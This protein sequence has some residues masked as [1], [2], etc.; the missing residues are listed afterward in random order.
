MSSAP[1]LLS[2][3]VPAHCPPQFSYRNE[4]QHL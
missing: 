2:Q 4:M 3:A 1:A